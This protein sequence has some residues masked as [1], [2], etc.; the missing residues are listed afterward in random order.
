VRIGSVAPVFKK[1][2]KQ[3]SDEDRQSIENAL[4]LIEVDLNHPSLRVRPIEGRTE[5]WEARASRALRL[6]FSFLDE[7]R[8]RLRTNCT[9]DQVYR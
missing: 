8:I 1:R 5:I 7:R 4:R 3:K 2:L 9:H 6:S